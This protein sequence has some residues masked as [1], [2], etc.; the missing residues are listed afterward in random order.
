MATVA[1]N[2]VQ[3]PAFWFR[4][5]MTVTCGVMLFGLAMVFAP[6]LTARGFGLLLYADS[7]RITTLDPMAIR[8]IALLH[9]VLGAVLFGWGVALLLIV[10]GPY[11]HG[12][13]YGWNIIAVSVLA[14]SI[15]DTMLSLWMGFFSQVRTSVA[16]G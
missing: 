15:P 2:P 4:W 13:R 11:R 10:R 8:H 12:H 1:E 9:G 7:H 14:W 6:D 16:R 5:L 3:P